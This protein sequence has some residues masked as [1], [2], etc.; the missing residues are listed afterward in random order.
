ML[1]KITLFITLICS[2]SVFHSQDPLFTQFFSNALQLNPALAGR[3]LSPRFH[4]TYRNQWPEINNGYIT[5]NIEYDQFADKLHGGIGF[6]LLH[7]QTGSGALNTTSFSSIYSY[8][9]AINR[10]WTVNFGMKASFVQKSLDW[11]DAIWGDQ[12]DPAL[13]VVNPT[14]QPQGNNAL[15]VDFNSGILLFSKNLFLGASI[16]HLTRPKET[17]FYNISGSN[18]TNKIP[19]RSSF[20]GGYKIRVL[21]NG[22]FHKEL[23]LSPEFVIDLQSNLKRY[24]FGTYF[25]DG[26]FDLGFWYRHTRFLDANNENYSPQDAF[27][28]VIGV[29]KN[30]LRFGYSYDF[31][32]SNIATSSLGAHEISFTID[33]PE[34]RKH[35]SK[36]R[37]IQCPQF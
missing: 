25:V 21:Q 35:D 11:G 19:I 17:F 23:F 5:Y 20:H 13:G 8:Q 33:L 16:D 29:E 7:D 6:Q 2:V 15:Y 32:I 24:N 9:L 37:V 10:D 31:N 30:N 14:S 1:K 4:T 36:F 12:I 28:V 3:D 27:V 18:S 26:I 34:K 22:L